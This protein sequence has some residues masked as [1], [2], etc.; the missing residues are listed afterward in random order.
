MVLIIKN[1]ADNGHNRNDFKEKHHVLCGNI[2]AHKEKQKNSNQLHKCASVALDNIT[3]WHYA[4][5]NHK[6][7]Y[8]ILVRST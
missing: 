5:G 4:C 6:G 2:S 3:C 8:V 1:G 7:T